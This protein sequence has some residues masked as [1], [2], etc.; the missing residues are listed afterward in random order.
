MLTAWERNDD[1][2][3]SPGLFDLIVLACMDDG[4]TLERLQSGIDPL[5]IIDDIGTEVHVQQSGDGV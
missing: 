5:Q 4:V 3:A 2:I 1:Q